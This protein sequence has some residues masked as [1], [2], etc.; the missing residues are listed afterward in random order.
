MRQLTIIIILIC[1]SSIWC[2]YLTSESIVDQLYKEARKNSSLQVSLANRLFG[3]FS[4]IKDKFYNAM[5]SP[6]YKA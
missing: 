4:K 6:G 3:S 5:K 1:I 2:R